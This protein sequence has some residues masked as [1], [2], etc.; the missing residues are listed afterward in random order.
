MCV[1]FV[2]GWGEM[3]VRFVPGGGEMCVRFVRGG[4]E[5]CVQLA[6]RGVG[7]EEEHTCSKYCVGPITVV[8]IDR[9][10]FSVE[11]NLPR[12]RCA[13]ES[14]AR[15]EGWLCSRPPRASALQQP[16]ARCPPRACRR[17]VRGWGEMCVQSVRGCGEM[18]VQSV[19]GCGEM[20]V[21]FVR[22][23]G[24]MCIRFVRGWGEM[25][26]RFVRRLEEMCVRFVRGRMGGRTR[27]SCRCWS[28]GAR[29]GPARSPPQP[30][31][32]AVVSLLRAQQSVSPMSTSQS[33]GKGGG[34]RRRQAR[35]RCRA[36]SGRGARACSCAAR[37]AA[38]VSS[39]EM[40]RNTIWRLSPL[41][42]S[43]SELRRARASALR[44]DR[45]RAGEARRCRGAMLCRAA[46]T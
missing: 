23:W 35:R 6:R 41:G 2:R 32:C 14:A 31:S 29:P 26:V 28:C 33:G 9:S 24:D 13:R 10:G 17:L 5:M 37:K 3:C 30:A 20:C 25:C 42:W 34:A 21:R 19:R 7:G 27:S 1:Q 39:R 45:A 44:R 15:P 36:R 12:A 46:D 40:M 8:L 16:A 18:C 4:G 11:R 43:R 22:G 38:S